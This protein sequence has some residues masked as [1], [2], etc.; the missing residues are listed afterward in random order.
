MTDKEK[1]EEYLNRAKNLLSSGGFFSR[2]M[3]HKPD[4]EE[5][6]IMYKKA[7]TRFKVAQLWKDAALA[8]MAAAKIYENDKNEK[9]ATAENY[10]EAGNCFRKESPNDA[11][12]A[13]QKSIDIYFEMVS[14]FLKI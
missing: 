1:A 7:G 9:Y 4:A 13:Y 3:G 5:A 12:N 2:M 10:A 11:L 6:M 8:Y 14:Q